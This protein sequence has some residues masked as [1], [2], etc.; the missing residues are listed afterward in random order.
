M[1]WIRVIFLIICQYLMFGILLK[2]IGNVMIKIANKLR[3]SNPSFIASYKHK[4]MERDE[5]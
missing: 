1:E 3:I 2:I 4:L 5:H